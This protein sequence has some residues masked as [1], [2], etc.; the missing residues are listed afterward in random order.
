MTGTDE[1][2]EKIHCVDCVTADV[3]SRSRSS[4]ARSNPVYIDISGEKQHITAQISAAMESHGKE[5]LKG[6]VLHIVVVGFHHKKGCQVRQA[7]VAC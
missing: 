7:R 4:T 2:E 6:P 5:E 1:E 3:D